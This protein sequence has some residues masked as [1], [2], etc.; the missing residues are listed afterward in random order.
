VIR[1]LISIVTPSFNQGR[2]IRE[3]LGS[4]A[5]QS[6][7]PVEHIVMD[8]GSSDGSVEV[9]QEFA[10]DRKNAHLHWV[11]EEDRGQSHALNKGFRLAQ[12]EYIGWLNADDRY[13]AGCFSRVGQAFRD[14]P[15][16]DVI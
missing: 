2:Y 3:S 10:A 15:Q 13:R 12:G 5:T 9:L 8:G 6:G 4:V 16:V 14:N 7:G 11:S 1:P